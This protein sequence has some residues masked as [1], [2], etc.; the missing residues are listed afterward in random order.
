MKNQIRPLI[1]LFAFTLGDHWSYLSSSCHR[2]ITSVLPIS[3]EWQ[4]CY[5][6]RIKWWDQNL[7]VRILQVT[8][9]SGGDLQQ[10]RGNP[11]MLSTRQILTGSSGSNLGPLSQSLVDS[12]QDRVNFLQRADPGNQ[13][14][15]P[16]DLVTASGIRI[17][18]SYQCCCGNLP[19]SPCSTIPWNE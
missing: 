4:S 16:V 11:I 13:L 5:S 17:G 9:I 15:I 6:K 2:I 7:S 8:S 19:G 14:L 18:P 12:V 10:P 3:G 1:T